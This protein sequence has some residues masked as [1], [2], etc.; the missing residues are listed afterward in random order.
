MSDLLSTLVEIK[1]RILLVDNDPGARVSYQAL[2]M[3]WGYNPVLAMGIGSGLV[4]DALQKAHEKRCSLALVDL[5][6]KDDDNEQ[7]MSG[8]HLAEKLKTQLKPIILTGTEDPNALR[9]LLQDYQ[10]IPFFGKHD[11][12]DEFHQ[13]LDIE[14]AKISAVKRGLRIENLD[15]L[16]DF[17]NSDL[18]KQ[19]GENFDQ[20]LDV[21]ARLFPNAIELKLERLSSN[22]YPSNISTAPRPN[23]IVLMVYESD[24]SPYVVKIARAGKIQKESSNYIKYISRR[25]TE[26]FAARLDRSSTVWDIGG[27]SYTMVENFGAKSFSTFYENN[28]IREIEEVLH[29]FFCVAWAH[30][31]NQVK[32]KNN[33]SLYNLYSTVW[34]EN[35]FEKRVKVFSPSDIMRLDKILNKFDLPEPIEWFKTNIATPE[36]D[37]SLFGKVSVAITHGDLHGDNLMVDDKKNVWVIDFERCGE[38]HALQDFIELEADIY[39]RLEIHNVNFSAYYKMCIL[40]LRQKSIQGFEIPSELTKDFRTKKALKT[41]SILRSLAQQ[42][43]KIS[44]AREYLLG[45][46]FNMLFHASIVHKI[47]PAKSERPLLLAGFICHRLDHW[48]EFWPPVE[49]NIS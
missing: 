21:F 29:S 47:D 27:I 16:A 20:I 1:P 6:L 13:R 48:D 24:F 37:K 28:Q 2:L 25:N 26:R 44:D 9:K 31:Y 49:W 10:D 4:E 38:G 7:D 18:G 41:I 12:R 42:Q 3:E 34:E 11:R 43:T 15:I 23:S 35:W 45:L 19:L 8:A 14:A 5:R 17:L 33:L 39:N 36:Q 22:S 40:A 30:H 46:L 32:A